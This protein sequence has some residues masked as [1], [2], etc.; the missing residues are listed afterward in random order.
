MWVN[1]T[2]FYN[3]F[4]RSAVSQ[5]KIIKKK[6]FTYR[7]IIKDVAGLTKGKNLKILD[8]GCGVGTLSLY[9]ASLGNEVVGL[10]ISSE[11]INVANQSAKLNGKI[12]KKIKFYTLSEGTKKV[13]SDFD[14]VLCIE[15]MEHVLH[16]KELLGF[17]VEKLKKGGYLILSV[18]SYNAPL[19]KLGLTKRFDAK[20][21]HLRRYTVENLLAVFENSGL[22]IREVIRREGIFRNILF[23]NPLFGNLIRFLK[24]VFSDI[25]TLIDD[26]SV[27]FFGESD[28]YIIARKK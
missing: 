26:L 16:E 27:P 11:A 17:L 4:H 3:R 7:I 1:N 13:S 25:Y 14:L 23:I 5:K 28:I 6:N 22:E 8:Y 19:Y 15:V 18:P 9:L 2:F 12:L 10:D 20:V 21:G 24:G